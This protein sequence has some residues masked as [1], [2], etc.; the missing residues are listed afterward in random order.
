MNLFIAY[1]LDSRSRDLYTAFR[2]S[3][4]LF[5]EV[6]LTRNA[7]PDNYGDSCYRIRFNASSQFSL[8]LP[9]CGANVDIFV[10]GNSF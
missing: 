1:K 4:C 7:D 5:G 6:K 9:K 8:P 3:N 2:L 10:V